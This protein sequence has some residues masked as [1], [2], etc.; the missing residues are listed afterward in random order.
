M[1]VLEFSLIWVNSGAL[2]KREEAGKH[3]ADTSFDGYKWRCK[4]RGL[5]KKKGR[6]HLL[7]AAL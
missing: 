4:S 7:S 1:A 2:A 6:R 5:A 3:A